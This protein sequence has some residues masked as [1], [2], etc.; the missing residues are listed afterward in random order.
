MRVHM[1]VESGQRHSITKKTGQ[2]SGSFMRVALSMFFD[3]GKA[4]QGRG[5]F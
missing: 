1:V 3:A 5:F 4:V 2:S